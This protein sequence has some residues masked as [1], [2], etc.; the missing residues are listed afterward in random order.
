MV[1][2]YA[3]VWLP[4]SGHCF[5]PRALRNTYLGSEAGL[6]LESIRIR[7]GK[8]VAQIRERSSAGLSKRA[9]RIENE[10]N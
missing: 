10:K 8:A 1:D 2:L 9:L 3:P 7:Y 6:P 5:K 4:I